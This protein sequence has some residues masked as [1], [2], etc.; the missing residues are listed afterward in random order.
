MSRERPS[1][2][3]LQRVRELLALRFLNNR[4][5]TRLFR[6]RV[7]AS[8]TAEEVVLEGVPSTSSI[9]AR[10]LR[11]SVPGIATFRL[12]WK[13][14]L[15]LEEIRPA[16]IE[17]QPLAGDERPRRPKRPEERTTDPE[18]PF[19]PDWKSDPSSP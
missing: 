6:V 19:H 12:E 16:E 18:L 9:A 14:I 5:R 7:R 17:D 3:G 8:K 13:H 15:A 4:N 1:G 11:L 2:S 10:H